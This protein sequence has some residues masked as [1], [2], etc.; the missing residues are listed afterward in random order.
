MKT[1]ILYGIIAVVI[2]SVLAY[3]L[4]PNEPLVVENTETEIIST[5]T[6]AVGAT[7]STTKKPTT[8]ST[9]PKTTYTILY[10][11]KGF[12]PSELQIPK[13]ATVKFVNKT[14]TA[15]RVFANDG[16]KPPYS[17][18]SQPKAVGINGEY[19]FNFIYT[20]VW[21]YYNSL[22]PSDVGNIVVY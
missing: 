4:W 1:K 17:D 18:L 6:T 13:G 15:M 5:T 3:V 9:A 7:K 12:E 16:A 10:T 14:G 8:T 19:V 22:K 11:S 21:S 20:G 2:V